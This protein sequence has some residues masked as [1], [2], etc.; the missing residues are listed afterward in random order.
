MI[1]NFWY[2]LAGSDTCEIKNP[3]TVVACFSN[4]FGHYPL[5]YAVIYKE[6]AK[7]NEMCIQ[8]IIEIKL[9]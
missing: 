7:D 9:L 8:S 5:G 4:I 3:E 1:L 6:I 2:N